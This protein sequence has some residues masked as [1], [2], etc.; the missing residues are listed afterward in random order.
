MAAPDVDLQR[1]TE[2]R[3]VLKRQ[4][5]ASLA[6]LSQAIH[7]CPD[8]LWLEKGDHAAAYW[9]VAFHALFFTHFYLA[10]DQNA[11]RRWE[12]HRDHWQDLDA[13]PDGLYTKA[14]MLDYLKHILERLGADVDA[15]DLAATDCGFPWYTQG[16]LEHQ[17]NNIRHTQH[18]AAQLGDRLR[19]ATGRGID[20]STSPS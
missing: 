5:R 19:A 15:M 14:E 12:H 9:H 20:W 13:H 16:K 11:F 2:I 10:I 1:P 7:R 4:Y 3:A 18:H 17:I 8:G 6:M